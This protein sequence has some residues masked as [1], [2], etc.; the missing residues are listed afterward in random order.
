MYARFDAASFMEGPSF[1]PSPPLHSG[2]HAHLDAGVA[3]EVEVKLRGVADPRVHDCPRERVAL[4]VAHALGGKEARVVAL[5]DD[6][7]GQCGAVRLFQL[8][9]RLR[10][11]TGKR[12]P[13]WTLILTAGTVNPKPEVPSP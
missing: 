3:H 13:P 12:E 1:Q 8:K 6:Y 7:E 2:A 4:A 10:K 9:A 11:G 5:L